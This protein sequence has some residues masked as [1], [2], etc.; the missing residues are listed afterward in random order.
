MD[1]LACWL[2]L[3]LIVV[4]ESKGQPGGDSWKHAANSRQGIEAGARASD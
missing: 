2:E 4:S 3:M 1:E